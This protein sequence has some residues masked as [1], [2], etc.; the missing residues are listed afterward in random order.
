MPKTLVVLLDDNRM[1]KLEGSGLEKQVVKLFGGALNAFNL[2]VS[3][4]DTQ[5]ILEEFAT[6]RIDSRGAIT[7]VPV[8]FNRVVFEE[9]AK[10][11]S[12]GPEVMKG[13]FARLAEIK[14]MAAKESEYL[15]PPDIDV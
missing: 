10:A 8:A 15:P 11:K 3:D 12:L 7:D 6:A 14:E 13:V 4:E 5:R 2:E 9:I 1:K